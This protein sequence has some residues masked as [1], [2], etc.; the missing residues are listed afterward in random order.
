MP[1]SGRA[2]FITRDM[3]MNIR[4]Q[5]TKKREKSIV[6]AHA[7]HL[8]RS[9]TEKKIRTEIR[10]KLMMSSATKGM[11]LRKSS[12]IIEFITAV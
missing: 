4:P 6:V 2:T 11:S 3:Y 8:A 5:K 7:N 12:L 9:F 10:T 1:R